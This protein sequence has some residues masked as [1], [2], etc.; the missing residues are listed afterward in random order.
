MAGPDQGQALRQLASLSLCFFKEVGFFR[1]SSTHGSP[2]LVLHLSR[3]RGQLSPQA[4][5]PQTLNP[6]L[7]RLS[8]GHSH[9]PKSYST[10]YA[11]VS[12]IHAFYLLCNLLPSSSLPSLPPSSVICCVICS[13]GLGL[14][15]SYLHSTSVPSARNLLRHPATLPPCQSQS[16]AP[17]A[18]QFPF[19]GVLR[20]FNLF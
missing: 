6:R 2:S 19:R 3:L 11:Y 14:P 16:E 5:K 10:A 15:C 9:R 8:T 7:L 17:G 12:F 1:S 18:A 13:F 20:S 4:P